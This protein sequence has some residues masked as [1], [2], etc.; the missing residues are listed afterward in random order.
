M[1]QVPTVSDSTDELARKIERNRELTEFAEHELMTAQHL[2]C[3]LW[4]FLEEHKSSITA[5]IAYMQSVNDFEKTRTTI[6]ALR[7]QRIELESRS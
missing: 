5:R 4:D 6:D 2:M 1:S 7:V 3:V